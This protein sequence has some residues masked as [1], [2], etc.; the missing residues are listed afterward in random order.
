MFPT[1]TYDSVSKISNRDKL[2]IIDALDSIEH[3]Y[4]NIKDENDQDMSN[5]DQT[6][7]PL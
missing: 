3:K 7:L 6:T 5:E 1:L 4:K 2:I